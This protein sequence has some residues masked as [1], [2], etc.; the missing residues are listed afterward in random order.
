ML[1]HGENVFLDDIT[2]EEI[3]KELGVEITVVE[4][5]G[6]AFCDAVEAL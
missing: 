1:R 3:E 2:L 4:P 5:D 6:F